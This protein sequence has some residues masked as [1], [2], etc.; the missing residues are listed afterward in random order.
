MT[1]DYHSEAEQILRRAQQV[2][3]Q[4][5]IAQ[6]VGDVPHRPSQ[7][8]YDMEL[9]ARILEEAA[10][11]LRAACSRIEQTRADRKENAE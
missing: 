9:A 2:G 10:A 8:E 7:A 1:I 3:A 5:R 6:Y 11:S 4:A